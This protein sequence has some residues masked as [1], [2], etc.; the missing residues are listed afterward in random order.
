MISK[1]KYR[2]ISDNYHR[3]D[4]GDDDDNSYHDGDDGSDDKSYHD[5]GYS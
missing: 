1:K 2:Y 4:G 5:G 3:H